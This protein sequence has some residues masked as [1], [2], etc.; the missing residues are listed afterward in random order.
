MFNP[1]IIIAGGKLPKLHYLD[2]VDR[3][4]G[5]LLTRHGHA[6][7]FGGGERLLPLQNVPF[8]AETRNQKP[9]GLQ[10]SCLHGS[11]HGSCPCKA[12][13]S[14]QKEGSD[15]FPSQAINVSCVVLKPHM[16]LGHIHFSKTGGWHMCLWAVL[17]L[18]LHIYV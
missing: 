2:V 17:V 14:P 11:V 12:R 5:G 15:H 9:C 7:G 3:C 10:S 13:P 8:V 16:F 1:Q 18:Q 6:H 4:A